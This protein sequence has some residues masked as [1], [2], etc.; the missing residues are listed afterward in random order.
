MLTYRLVEGE[1]ENAKQK[2]TAASVDDR[3]IHLQEEFHHLPLENEAENLHLPG[4]RVECHRE[5]VAQVMD[6]GGED[7]DQ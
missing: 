4:E 1:Q 6:Q 3:P 7:E 2:Q 5:I